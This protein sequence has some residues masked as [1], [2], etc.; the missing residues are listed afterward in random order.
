[1]SISL[2][3][4]KRKA[5]ISQPAPAGYVPGLGRGATGF[6][7]RSDIGPAREATDVPDERHARLQKKARPHEDDDDPPEPEE[8]DL[9]DAN[10]DEFSGYGGSLFSSGPYDADDREADQIYDTI[11]MRMDDRRKERREKKF[12]EEIEKYRQERPKI[13]QQFSDLKRQLAVVSDDDWLNIPEVG[14]AR[15]KKQRNAHIRP[16]R[17]TPVPDSVLQRALAGGHNSL[18]KQQQLLGG[19]AT[20]YPGTMTGT[21]TPGVSTSTRIDLNQIGEARNSMLGIKLDQVSDSVSGQTVVDPKGYLTDLN[22]ITPQTSGDVNDVKKARLLLK[23]VITTNPNHAPGWVA[24]ARLE[25]VTGRMQMARNIIMR[26]CEVCSKNEDVWV[27]SI[28]LQPPENA[29]LVV[30]QAIGHIPQSVKIWLKA[31]E[32]ESDVPAKRRVL[33]KALENIP[34]SV[35]L[36]KEAVELEEP[37]DARIL[38]GRAVECCPASVELWLALARLE[39]YDNARKVLNKAREN[40]P[41]DRKIWISAARLEESQNNIHMVSKIIERAISSLQSNGVEINRD[42]WIKE[43]EEANKSGSVHT[44]QAIIRL[45]IGY[46]IEEEDRLDQWTEDAESCAA[47]E[48]YEC[49]RAIYAHMLTVFP[50]QKNIWLEAAY[51]EKDHGSGESLEALLQKAVQNCPKA[52]VLWLMAAKSKW[53]AGDVPS[54]RSILSLAFQANPNSEEVWLAAVKLESENNEFERARIL[55]EKAWASAG[56]ARVMM[57]SVKLEWVLNNMEKAF[58][59]TRDALEKHPDF[60]K[61]WMMLGQ[62]NEQEGKIDE[63]RMSYIDALKKCPGSLP[64]W[65]LY[66]RLEEKSGQPTK[67]RS[68]LEKARL[69][70]PRSP[71]LWL[72]AIRL[73]MRGDR[74]PIAQN[75]MA[76]ALQECPSSGKLWAES[77]FMATRPQ[78]KT[79]S[80][81]ALKKCEHDPHVLLAVAKLF[82]TERKISKCREWFIRAIKIDPDQGD[83][84]AHYYKFELAHG[85]QE[86]QD[87]VLK[88]CVQAEPRHGET[89]CSVSKDIKNWQKHT[90]DILPLVTAAI[91]V[92]V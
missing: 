26:G 16:D 31:V 56:T 80:V 47:N 59:L 66:S 64:L 43:A 4:K 15:N 35:R 49:A 33:R 22:S 45:V 32:L 23:S 69:K 70:N 77:I 8:E 11:D 48:A 44:A 13:Q 42:Q 78:R 20:P 73:E 81:D 60:A 46:G 50:K 36:W 92:P 24:A 6:T 12:Q 54:A 75:L 19:F 57:K 25:E 53:L 55:L 88:R 10:Y 82:W 65:I 90:N 39:N 83:T 29:K 63:A 84:W 52:E 37:E 2:I 61:L 68:V 71:D 40:I 51:F 18:S 21:M 58:K 72:E 27:E 28:R 87:E 74:K 5:F 38:L 67:A 30:A 62:M 79:K 41:T 3:S 86:Q 14:D 7:T 34:S 17:Y 9:N 85:T 89:W 76:K 91:S 1:M